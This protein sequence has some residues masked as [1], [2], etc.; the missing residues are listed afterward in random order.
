MAA[1]LGEGAKEAVAGWRGTSLFEM[2][3][4]KVKLATVFF[5][6]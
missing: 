6:F 5:L 3:Q 4:G 2:P 1:D